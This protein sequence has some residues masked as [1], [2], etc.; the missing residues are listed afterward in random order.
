MNFN[1]RF[2]LRRVWGYI[3]ILG[4]GGGGVGGLKFKRIEGWASIV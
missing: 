2:L 1:H 3:R 4:G